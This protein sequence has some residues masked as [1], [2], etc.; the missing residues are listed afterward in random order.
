MTVMRCWRRGKA[1]WGLV[2]CIW[3]EER[4]CVRREHET[5]GEPTHPMYVVCFVCFVRPR[6]L[7]CVYASR[8]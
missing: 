5:D 4:V 1:V 2:F 7:S 8:I 6:L 3:R